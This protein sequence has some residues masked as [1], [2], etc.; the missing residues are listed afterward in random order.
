[1]YIDSVIHFVDFPLGFFFFLGIK[2]LEYPSR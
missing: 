2:R 1:M